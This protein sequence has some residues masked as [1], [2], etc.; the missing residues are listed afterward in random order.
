MPGRIILI[1]LDIGEYFLRFQARKFLYHKESTSDTRN[2][3]GHLKDSQKLQLR[4]QILCAVDKLYECVFEVR[5]IAS[6]AHT[7]MHVKRSL[8]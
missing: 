5:R 2:L 3:S 4:G 8:C 6:E 1:L 7:L